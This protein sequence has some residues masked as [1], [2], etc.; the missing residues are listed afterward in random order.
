MELE[1]TKKQ[2]LRI[3]FNSPVL[4]TFVLLCVAATALGQVTCGYLTEKLFMTYRAPITS[5][6]T[7][8]RA[9]TYIFGHAGWSHLVGNASYLL[10]LGPMLEE[11]YGSRLMLEIIGITAVVT[12]VIN[13]VFFPR[14]GLCGASGIVFAFILLASFT[15][16][17]DRE[18]PLT[19][20]LVA[21]I[22]I[23][24]QVYEGITVSDN[25]SN[26]AHIVG[27][28]CGAV[29]GYLLNSRFFDKKEGSAV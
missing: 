1:S 8:L 27:G 5:P 18:I 2:K 15:G 23:G 12:A 3:T 11:K 26:M 25:I 20:I 16:V 4:L 9:V 19:F 7:W 6:G 22:F 21:A 17:K 13:S 24:Q 28:I 10:L 14:V 29:M